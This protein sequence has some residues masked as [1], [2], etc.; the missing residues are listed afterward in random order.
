MFAADVERGYC[1]AGVQQRSLE[2]TPSD[3]RGASRRVVETL[4]R[5]QV[6]TYL[7]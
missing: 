2:K 5:S 4:A 6:T 1:E 7:F 3:L